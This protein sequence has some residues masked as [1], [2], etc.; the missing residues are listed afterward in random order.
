MIHKFLNRASL[1]GMS[2]LCFET[3]HRLV[4][5]V[6]PL[7][8]LSCQAHLKSTFHFAFCKTCFKRLKFIKGHACAYCGRLASSSAKDGRLHCLS[9]R[10]TKNFFDACITPL[11][12]TDVLKKAIYAFKYHGRSHY[13]YYLSCFMRGALSRSFSRRSL[14]EMM[15]VPVPLSRGRQ[16][17]RGYNQSEVLACHLARQLGLR[18][19][20][21]ALIR[22]AA[23]ESQTFL[24]RV[25]RQKNIRHAFSL[26]QDIDVT[27]RHII[28]VDDVLTT[29]ATLNECARILKKKGARKVTGLTL[30][31]V[32]LQ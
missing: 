21:Y 30:A 23:T 1:H 7:Y 3:K 26:S 2:Q 12:F 15:I 6:F 10:S 19:P 32:A 5:F 31:S 22:S 13:G 28:L 27:G 17:E 4:N 9:C 18:E 16:K 8:C 14:E 11:C 25:L 24:N 20:V 29:G